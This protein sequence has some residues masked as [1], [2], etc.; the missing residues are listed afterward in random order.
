MT[1]RTFTFSSGTQS[2]KH[3]RPKLKGCFRLT[4][5]CSTVSKCF[6]SQVSLETIRQ[7]VRHME[8]TEIKIFDKLHLLKTSISRN[9]RKIY[10]WL[11][12]SIRECMLLVC[13][14][15]SETSMAFAF[16]LTFSK[17][18]SYAVNFASAFS[19]FSLLFWV[20]SLAL[21]SRRYNWIVELVP[22]QWQF[23]LHLSA[24]WLDFLRFCSTWQRYHRI[25]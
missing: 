24:T 13:S 12:L 17:V 3:S 4:I 16:F 18:R 14:N 22:T 8:R 7:I 6:A 11:P 10:H 20:L 1:W 2:L 21:W 25:Y 19:T 9:T 15:E 23:R 5:C